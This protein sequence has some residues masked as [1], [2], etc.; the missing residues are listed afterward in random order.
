MKIFKTFLHSIKNTFI[1]KKEDFFFEQNKELLS[2]LENRLYV[3]EV[4]DLF[5]LDFKETVLKQKKFIDILSKGEKNKDYKKLALAMAKNYLANDNQELKEKM[6]MFSFFL[7]EGILS[8]SIFDYQFNSK[9]K[10]LHS[11]YQTSPVDLH[12]YDKKNMFEF[13][14]YKCCPSSFSLS[15]IGKKNIA[16]EDL[17]LNEQT[18]INFFQFIISKPELSQKLIKKNEKE[19]IQMFDKYYNMYTDNYMIKEIIKPLCMAGL[20]INL[21]NRSVLDSNSAMLNDKDKIKSYIKVFQE[22]KYFDSI[23]I[24]KNNTLEPSINKSKKKL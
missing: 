22:K 12:F 17:T 19:I 15:L 21:L 2:N 18:Y 4:L 14:V 9:F 1:A 11:P 23:L 24:N 5:N 8:S 6:L 10:S 7:K 16:Q 3:R 13:I 20:D